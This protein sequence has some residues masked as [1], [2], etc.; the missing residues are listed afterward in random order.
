MSRA[1]RRLLWSAFFALAFVAGLMPEP[2]PQLWM[3]AV[4]LGAAMGFVVL[5]T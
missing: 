3:L 1:A 4:V 2:I 5:L